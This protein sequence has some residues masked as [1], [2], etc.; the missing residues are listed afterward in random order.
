MALNEYTAKDIS[1]SGIDSSAKLDVAMLM[2]YSILTN[3]GAAVSLIGGRALRLNASG[4]LETGNVTNAQ[5]EYLKNLS[6]DLQ[7]SLDS[8]GDLTG[9]NSWSGVNTFSETIKGNC[10]K[11]LTKITHADGTPASPYDIENTDGYNEIILPVNASG[12]SVGV[13]IATSMLSK[14]TLITIVDVAGGMIA[15][16]YQIDITVEGGETINGVTTYSLTS[17]RDSITVFQAGS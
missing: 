14:N 11:W 3:S 17:D 1:G 9:A 13:Q 2:L 16:G 5:L 12:G 8:K 4:Y 15:G 7:G 6:G 10:T